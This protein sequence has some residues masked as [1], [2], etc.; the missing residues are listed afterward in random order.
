MQ[1]ILICECDSKSRSDYHYIKATIDKNY[2]LREKNIKLSP[3]YLAGKGNW[4]KKERQINDYRSKYRSTGGTKVIF[5]LDYD[6][7]KKTNN[8]IAK[9]N[10]IE[11]Y[12]EQKDYELVWFNG[13][14]EQVFLGRDIRKSEKVKEAE[15]F[16]SSRKIKTFDTNKLSINKITLKI[17]GSNLLVVLDKLI[18]NTRRVN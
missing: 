8:S 10:E 16:L 1:I 3:I 11:K 6:D 14:I 2:D 13:N 7:P 5:C 9:N 18:G 15:K 12:C 4:N 17:K